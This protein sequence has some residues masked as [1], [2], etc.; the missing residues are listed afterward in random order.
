M[1]IWVELGIFAMVL[2]F[3]LWQ[4][5]DVKKTIA[6]RKRAEKPPPGSAHSANPREGGKAQN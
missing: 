6:A 1:G 3:G 4:L 5:W 2:A